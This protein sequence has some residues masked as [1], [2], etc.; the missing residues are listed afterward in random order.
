[1]SCMV[2][3]Y[4][5]YFLLAILVCRQS[6][7]TVTE[8]H[9]STCPI[10][11]LSCLPT[12]L[13]PRASNPWYPSYCLVQGTPQRKPSTSRQCL[14]HWEDSRLPFSKRPADRNPQPGRFQTLS[15]RVFLANP[16]S[17]ALSV[18]RL[19]TQTSI[20]KQR[21]MIYP[22]NP[23]GSLEKDHNPNVSQDGRCLNVSTK[24]E[25]FGHTFF[26]RLCW[27]KSSRRGD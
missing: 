22:C 25:P 19:Y 10:C 4:T 26:R 7:L 27:S 2:I 3:V 15:I 18:R 24:R 20:A 11:F 13:E 21:Q 8:D 23:M 5:T 1:M 14:Y 9:G 16:I 17:Y 6:F 12:A